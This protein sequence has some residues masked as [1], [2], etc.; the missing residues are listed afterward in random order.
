MT[1]EI[2]DRHVSDHLSV[3]GGATYIVRGTVHEV[4]FSGEDALDAYL[5]YESLTRSGFTHSGG[6]PY[7]RAN[8]YYPESGEKY[9]EIHCIYR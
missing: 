6:T 9:A 1:T 8:I 7:A 3:C 4:M 2:Q 5:E